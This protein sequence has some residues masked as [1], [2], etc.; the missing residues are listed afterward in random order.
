VADE[1]IEKMRNR[2]YQI[3]ENKGRP[4]GRDLEHWL[5]AE[6]ELEAAD[7]RNRRAIKGEAGVGSGAAI[8][9][10][11]KSSVGTRMSLPELRKRSTP[12]RAPKIQ[13]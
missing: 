5:E 12:S 11:F 13:N 6:G 3:W 8:I 2:A 4:H 9:E 10:T 1:K 7:D